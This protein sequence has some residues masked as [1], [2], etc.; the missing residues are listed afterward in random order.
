M[1]R[2]EAIQALVVMICSTGV[3]AAEPSVSTLIGT[4]SPGLSDREVN[5]PYGLVI[6]PDRA[7]YF[8]DLDNQRVRRLGL[9]TRR[10]T[11]IAW[12]V[13]FFIAPAVIHPPGDPAQGHSN[14]AAEYRG[15]GD[16]CLRPNDR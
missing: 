14:P 8:C 1:N 2:R 4:G 3:D 12:P 10:T 9:R 11:T 5:N 16:A 13:L 15:R 6:G 7:L